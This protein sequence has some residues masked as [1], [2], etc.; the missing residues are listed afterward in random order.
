M[1][2]DEKW[3]LFDNQ[4]W[5][6][7]WLDWE[8][9]PKHFPKSNL[10]QNKVMVTVWW[11]AA[12]LTHYSFLSPSEIITSEKYAQQIDEIHW[13]LQCLQAGIGQQM[14]PILLHD[15]ANCMS[16]KQHFKSWTSWVQSFPHPP[17][18]PELLPIDYHFFKHF[19]DFLQGK[20][21]HNQK[22][23]GNASQELVESWSMDFYATGMNLFLIGQNVLLVMLPILMNKDVFEL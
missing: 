6:A 21:F 20:C 13:K 22:E 15:C 5:P 18:S 11:S 14:G 2:C 3:I 12:H 23:A 9:T 16:H 19:D 4:Q 17:C 10:H 1:T 7:Q 8:E